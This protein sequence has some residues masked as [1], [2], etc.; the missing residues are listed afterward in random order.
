MACYCKQEA[1]PPL[2]NSKEESALW[3]PL[4]QPTFSFHNMLK[5]WGPPSL[6]SN[7]YLGLFTWGKAD[8]S[9]HLM[10]MP[11]MRGAIQPLP[12]YAFMAWSKYKGPEGGFYIEILILDVIKKPKTAH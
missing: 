5:F 6:L 12:Q 3:Y 8:H 2:P 4:P 11:R 7:G 1:T 10:P 9:P